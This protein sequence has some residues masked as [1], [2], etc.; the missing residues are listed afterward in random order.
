[1]YTMLTCPPQKFFQAQLKAAQKV[2]QEPAQPKIKLKV[3]QQQQ[4]SESTPT[5]AKKITIHVGNGRVDSPTPAAA[6]P[7]PAAA[8]QHTSMSLAPV[9]KARSVSVAA[10]SP[11]PSVQASQLP[12]SPAVRPPSVSSNTATTP[13]PPAAPVPVAPPAPVIPLEPKR[14]RAP[15]K[16]AKDA[17]LSSLRLHL[18]SHLHGLPTTATVLPDPLSTTQSATLTVPGE[19]GRATLVARLP[20]FLDE[21]Q[22]CLWTLYERQPLKTSIAPPLADQTARDRVFETMLHP[23]LNTVEAH[24][25]AAIPRAER[26]PGGPEVE[27]EVFTV[28]VNVGRS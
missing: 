21:R 19:Y 25:V 15:G 5:A 10:A 20:E 9:D 6:S 16:T 14:P 2:V 12:G 17:L 1:M 3:G 28:Y 7:A 4:Q 26:V 18:Y 13:Y 27:L 23:G 8:A 24:L 11:S 22:Y